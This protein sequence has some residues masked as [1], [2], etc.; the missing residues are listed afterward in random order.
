MRQFFLSLTALT[1]LTFAITGCSEHA[2]D[3][4][5]RSHPP[6]FSNIS[7]T[8]LGGETTL[9]VGTPIVAAAEQS[10]IGRLLSRA[11]YAWSCSPSDGVDHKP[12]RE[13]VIYDKETAN[14]TDTITFT[15]PGTYTLTLSA[16]YTVSGSN[17]ENVNLTERF[18][19]GEATYSS[20][21]V[22]YIISV[23]KTFRVTN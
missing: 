3:A 21:A 13:S 7:L 2:D 15:S 11:T 8:P 23:K 19:G 18:D 12:S 9:K 16:R 14:P 22:S 10:S 20:S 6:R 4:E 5:Y 1:A 17:Y